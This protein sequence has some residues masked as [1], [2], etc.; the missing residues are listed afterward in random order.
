M[1]DKSHC[2]MNVGDE[3]EYEQYYDFSRTYSDHQPSTDESGED[4]TKDV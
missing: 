4:D 2:F 1:M 3:H